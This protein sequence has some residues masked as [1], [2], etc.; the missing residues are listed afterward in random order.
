[1]KCQN[2]DGCDGVLDLDSQ[3]IRIRVEGEEER[4]VYV[5]PKCGRLHR[6]HGDGTPAPCPF[7]FPS[8][9]PRSGLRL[10]GF[11]EN[12]KVVRRK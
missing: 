8:Y 12:G 4:T 2:E 10:R 7:I 1:M 6:A 3:W 9:G 5:C 11:L